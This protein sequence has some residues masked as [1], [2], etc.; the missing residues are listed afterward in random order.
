MDVIT[1]VR[2][3]MARRLHEVETQKGFK[4][5][6]TEQFVRDHAD[7]INWIDV[8]PGLEPWEVAH[9]LSL[10]LDGIPEEGLFKRLRL[11]WFRSGLFNVGWLYREN[12][13]TSA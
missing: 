2:N 10:L 7:F 9:H 12:N 13:A 3:S 6:R 1:C 11:D 4:P 5:L 8:T